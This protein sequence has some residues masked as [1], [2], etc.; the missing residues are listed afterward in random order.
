MTSTRVLTASALAVLAGLILAATALAATSPAAVR[1]V[2]YS[3]L[4]V[5]AVPTTAT[6]RLTYTDSS[7]IS[8]DAQLVLDGRHDA[9][10]VSG[11]VSLDSVDVSLTAR[12]L[13]HQL[14]VD[15]P[16]FATLLG[17]PWTD[18]ALTRGE[19]GVDAAL[20]ELRHPYFEPRHYRPSTAPGRTSAVY[21][22][23]VRWVTLP[24]TFG[25]P[26]YLPHRAHLH[27]WVRIGAQGQ[28]LA[29]RLHYW[30]K[31]DDVRVTLEVTGYDQPLALAAPGHD[32][33]VDLTLSRAR[34]IFGDNAMGIEQLLAH[35]GAR[36]SPT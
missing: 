7:G 23:Q 22:H 17:A 9:A 16:Q 3:R 28:V 32:E 2:P 30:N 33:V 31:H 10:Q 26:I 36:L 18:V 14:F 4:V 27:L 34:S 29:A 11:T 35:L 24:S 21:T 15:L 6:V 13:G 1:N 19:R 5:G 25:L 20:R 8:I 12:L